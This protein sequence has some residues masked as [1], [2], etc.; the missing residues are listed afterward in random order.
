MRRIKNMLAQVVKIL[1]VVI[2]AIVIFGAVPI[3]STIKV[4][5]PITILGL[6]LLSIFMLIRTG[7]RRESRAT[8]VRLMKPVPWI[9]KG[10]SVAIIV[11]G[12][13][14][15]IMF[16]NDNGSFFNSAIIVIV[17][18]VLLCITTLISYVRQGGWRSLL[19]LLRSTR[20]RLTLWYAALLAIILFSFSSIVYAT[21]QHNLKMMLN[22]SLHAR[23]AQ[24]A[25]TYDPQKGLPQ[26]IFTNDG[27]SYK[28]SSSEFVL[29]MTPQGHVLQESGLPEEIT[30]LLV[31]STLKQFLSWQASQPFN[32]K[33][34]FVYDTS[35]G[36]KFFTSAATPL[37]PAGGTFEAY[38]F[39]DTTSYWLPGGNY[40]FTQAAIVDKQQAVALFAVGIPSDAPFLLND[41]SS[42]LAIAMP[43]C[44][45]LSS[46]GGYWLASRAMRPVQTITRTAQEISETDLHRRL[47]LKRRDELGQLGATFDS[48]LARLEAA[49]E[50]Q[51]QFT[52]DASHEL[53]TP[54]TIV[55]LEATRALTHKLTAQQ[56]QQAIAVMQQENRHMTHL[57]NDLLVLARADSGQAKFQREVIDL[58][59]VVVDTV[60]RLAPLAQQT[61]ITI[62]VH[63][64]PELT[65][66]GDRMY[67][68]QLL[69]NLVENALT[70]SSGIGTHVDI[71]LVCQYKQGQAWANLCIA[72]NGPGIAQEHLPHLFERFYRVDRS[73]THNQNLPF[74]TCSASSRPPGNGLGLSIA[75]WIVQAHDGEICVQSAVGLGATFEIWLPIALTL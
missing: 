26:S 8:I 72:D 19:H 38:N 25:S 33:P 28:L 74:E 10:L 29:L 68:M 44:L 49:F 71:D 65:I 20:L 27:S 47:N 73:R 41:L 18:L 3:G 52:A 40:E 12:M 56:Y 36:S 39:G 66:L 16:K 21:E 5:G 7:W 59:D 32:Q 14:A 13:I 43:L 58:S 64:L 60:E 63:P 75:R 55:D 24:I 4:I 53:R 54:L 6:L 70:Y 42:V 30:N 62:R 23:L 1:A 50:R 15:L 37:G 67:L 9:Y 46:V 17:D 48:M 61:G 69:T 35:T 57:V 2:I 31:K 51:R 11:V 45:L 22:D 34:G